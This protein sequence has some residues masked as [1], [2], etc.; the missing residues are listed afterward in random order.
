MNECKNTCVLFTNNVLLNK[1]IDT[2]TRKASARL[3]FLRRSL[4]LA[5]P[6][7]K[8]L[9]YKTLVRPLLKYADM[10]WDPFTASN[11]SSLE[12]IERKAVRFICN[13][14]RTTDSLTYICALL[15]TFSH[16]K[17][18]AKL[19]AWSFYMTSFIKTLKSSWMTI[20]LSYP[21]PTRNRNSMSLTTSPCLTDTYKYSF[22]PKT[23][24]ERNFLPYNISSS[25]FFTPILA[26]V[27]G[28]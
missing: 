24:A 26:H 10:I 8:P 14:Y 12:K 4:K 2:I 11:I 3:R 16:S 15:P 21:R 25:S 27:T 20:L 17:L 22:F 7:L 28:S 5:P 19:I 18:D 6:N 23:I 9:S 13:K 1:H